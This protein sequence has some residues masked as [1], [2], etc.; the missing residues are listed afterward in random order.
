MSSIMSELAPIEKNKA[1]SFLNRTVEKSSL[2]QIKVKNDERVVNTFLKK[3]NSRRHFYLGDKFEHLQ[4]GTEVTIKVIVDEKLFFIKT[5]LKKAENYFY[6]DNFDNFFELVRRKKPRFKIPQ[7]W[8]QSAYIQSLAT[9][10]ELKSTASIVEMSKAGMKLKIGPELPRYEDGL[11]IK[12]NFKIFRRAEI[13]LKAKIIH[14]K[15]TKSGGPIIGVRFLDLSNLSQN[16][17]QNVCDDLAFYHTASSQ[18]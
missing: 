2:I 4:V 18:L 3:M 11:E 7:K 9:P 13:S 5:E 8:S 1:Y 15:K 12:V 14:V 6:F 17:I 10:Y 16:K